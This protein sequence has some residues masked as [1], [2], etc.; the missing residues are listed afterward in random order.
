MRARGMRERVN[1]ER[2][3][4][5]GEGAS[6]AISDRCRGRQSGAKREQVSEMNI[7]G[8]RSTRRAWFGRYSWAREGQR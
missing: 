4:R 1:T 6:S 2:V 8:V 3:E 7:F 5:M